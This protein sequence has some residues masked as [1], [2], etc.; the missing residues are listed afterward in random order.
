MHHNMSHLYASS[1]SSARITV[2]P[3]V[4]VEKFIPI[5]GRRKTPLF[6]QPVA[7][8]LIVLFRAYLKYLPMQ[9]QHG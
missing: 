3:R 6:P 2:N 7:Y 4:E 1:S 5:L 8:L 9:M